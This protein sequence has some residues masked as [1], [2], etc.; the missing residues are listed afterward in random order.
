MNQRYPQS[1]H[2][3]HCGSEKTDTE[4]GTRARKNL[5]KFTRDAD[6]ATADGGQ[7]RTKLNCESV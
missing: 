6:D 1:R 2:T 5:R 3:P 7:R 4:K